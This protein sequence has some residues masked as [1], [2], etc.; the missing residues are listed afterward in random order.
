MGSLMGGWDRPVQ[1]PKSVKCMRNR[2]LTKEEI[3]SFWKEKKKTEQ[4][5]L[6]ALSP[7]SQ[8]VD[9]TT[10]QEELSLIEEESVNRQYVR[11]NSL[12]ASIRQVVPQEDDHDHE[13]G[14]KHEL[15]DLKNKFKK[16][17]WWTRSNWAFLNEPPVIEGE[18][19]RYKYASQYHVAKGS[20][21]GTSMPPSTMS[22]TVAAAS[23]MVAGKPKPMTTPH[24]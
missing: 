10:M 22:P 14:H 8:S 1:D 21:R 5:H 9:H 20:S 2:S 6:E 18:Q 17:C 3:D 24:C 15:D 12:P 16:N 4:E 19:P 11:S 23:A 13:Q 7:R